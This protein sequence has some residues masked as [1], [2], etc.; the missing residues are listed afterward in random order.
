MRRLVKQFEIVGVEPVVAI[1]Q[2]VEDAR[3][4]A[5]RGDGCASQIR[6]QWEILK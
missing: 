4:V 5:M 6:Y 2:P 1:A 3:I